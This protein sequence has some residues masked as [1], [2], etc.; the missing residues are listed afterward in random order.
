MEPGTVLP[1]R[2]PKPPHV[3][4]IIIE[5]RRYTGAKARHVVCLI[6]PLQSLQFVK[7]IFPRRQLRV[8]T[9]SAKELVLLAS[10]LP[11]VQ[12]P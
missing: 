2:P 4:V 11:T 10:S 1:G 8:N 9:A 7:Q 5:P 3:V 6:L 12:R